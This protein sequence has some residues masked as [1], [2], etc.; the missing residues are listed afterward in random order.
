MDMAYIYVDCEVTG[1]QWWLP[2]A[3]TMLTLVGLLLWW[4]GVIGSWTFIRLGGASLSL[5]MLGWG[6][7]LARRKHDAKGFDVIRKD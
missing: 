3:S 4:Q 1:K 5:S 6:L 7:D 2:V